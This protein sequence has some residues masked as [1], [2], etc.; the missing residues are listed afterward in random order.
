MRVKR[1]NGY[2]Q[3]RVL[4]TQR[5]ADDLFLADAE[6]AADPPLMLELSGMPVPLIMSL[7]GTKS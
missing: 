3:T 4:A 5:G 7:L 6:A 1:D 2:A